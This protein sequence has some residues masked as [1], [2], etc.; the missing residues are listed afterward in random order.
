MFKVFGSYEIVFEFSSD[1]SIRSTVFSLQLRKT[2]LSSLPLR[3]GPSTVRSRSSRP[4]R[5]RAPNLTEPPNVTFPRT[6]AAFVDSVAM[7]AVASRV[8]SPTESEK[9]RRKRPLRRRVRAPLY[10]FR[11]RFRVVH[12]G[13]KTT[14]RVPMKRN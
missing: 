10:A 12:A 4:S 1:R 7:V 11:Y 8:C 9:N 5:D 2:R 6:T 14:R 13:R 3:S